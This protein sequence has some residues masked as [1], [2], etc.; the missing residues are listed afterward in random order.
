[1]RKEVLRKHRAHIRT[2]GVCAEHPAV[3]TANEGGKTT[4]GTLGTNVEAVDG[5]LADRKR[6]LGEAR[7]ASAQLRL[8]RRILYVAMR[9]IVKVARSVGLSDPTLL[10]IPYPSRTGDENLL[11]SARGLVDRVTPH[12][13]A[14]V[15]A[16]LPSDLLANLAIQI[17]A[18]A[19]AKSA[20][21]TA[22]QQFTA[23]ATVIREKQEASD[24]AVDVLEAIA[25]TG[26]GSSAEIL[27][28]FRIA[29]RIG[30]HVDHKA[31]APAA[32]PQT[33]SAAP[34]ATQTA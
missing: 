4:L 10:G 28:K 26:P 16:G 17:Q 3:F 5:Q 29:R 27:T 12:A 33:A 22:R 18:F 25:E 20:L 31:D 23:V 7:A 13:D 6:Y 21:A 24:K 14:F 11:A 34:A 2:R 15:A 1:M 30:P 9:A 8:Y 19:A 32:A